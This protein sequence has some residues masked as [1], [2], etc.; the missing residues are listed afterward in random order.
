MKCKP[1]NSM[2]LSLRLSLEN[3]SKQPSTVIY[4]KFAYGNCN[5]ID[6]LQKHSKCSF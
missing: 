1:I 3:Y 2:K 6:S 5:L 4:F